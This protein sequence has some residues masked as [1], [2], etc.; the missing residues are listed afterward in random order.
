[1]PDELMK[2]IMKMVNEDINSNINQAK[3]E[4]IQKKMVFKNVEN[5]AEINRKM[6]D[7]HIKVGF[8]KEEALQLVCAI[9]GKIS[10]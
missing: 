8:S 1:M 9:T 5:I 2:V 7:A 10:K 3:F 6:Y 4:E